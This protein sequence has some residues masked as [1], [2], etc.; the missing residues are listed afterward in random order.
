MRLFFSMY[1]FCN[2]QLFKVSFWALSQRQRNNA[3]CKTG[4]HPEIS[5]TIS[6]N[7]GSAKKG[8]PNSYVRCGRQWAV[9]HQ[10]EGCGRKIFGC[11]PFK[12]DLLPER[13][14]YFISLIVSG[15]CRLSP[16]RLG[17]GRQSKVLK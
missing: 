4:N 16:S 8:V 17:F 10:I 9:T 12:Y 3:Y 14:Q 2:G 15:L 5:R 1:G 6:N 11:V 7:K 13:H